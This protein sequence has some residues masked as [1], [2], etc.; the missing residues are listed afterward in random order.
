MDHKLES[1]LNSA[2]NSDFSE[3]TSK[4]RDKK[5][6]ADDY[7]AIAGSPEFKS[8]VKKKNSFLVPVSI[9]FLLFYFTLPI[10]TSFTDVLS[11][12]VIGDITLVWIFALA[13]FIMTWTLC[14]IYVNKANKFDKEAESIIE[15]VKG[16]D[17]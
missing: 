15:K 3:K 6:T 8:L 13:Q 16:G 17:F 5:I 9:F 2:K 14:M 11:V 4:K 1:V 10:L 7:V 12:K